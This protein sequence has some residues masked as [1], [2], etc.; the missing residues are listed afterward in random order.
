MR[1]RLLAGTI[2]ALAAWGCGNSGGY[3]TTSMSMPSPTTAA[4]PATSTVNIVGQRNALSFD[5]NPA[6]ISQGSLVVWHNMDTTAHHIVMNDGSFDSS[7]I[8]PGGSSPAMRLGSAGGNYH[9][10]IH[11]T[12]MFGSINVATMEPSPS[13]GY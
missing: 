11:P 9:C 4:T 5:P 7:T 6:P 12:T 2:L 8:A 1:A 3:D 10:T 13:P